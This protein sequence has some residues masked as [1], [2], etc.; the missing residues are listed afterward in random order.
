MKFAKRHVAKEA[1]KTPQIPYKAGIN[2]RQS[3]AHLLAETITKLKTKCNQRFQL[4]FI[5]FQ[6]YVRSRAFFSPLRVLINFVLPTFVCCM[7]I[8]AH[9][10]CLMA[11]ATDSRNAKLQTISRQREV[12]GE[13]ER[14]VRTGMHAWQQ[15]Q[16][17][18]GKWQQ[19]QAVISSVN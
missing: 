5:L 9:I 18:G 6:G 1:E 13:G 4:V 7:E 8:H 14:G 17:A 10:L 19:L 15:Q 3:P 12:Q 2:C 11:A 16:Q